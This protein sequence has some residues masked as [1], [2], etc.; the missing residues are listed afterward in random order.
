MAIYKIDPLI[1]TIEFK[2]KH[3][4]IANVNGRFTNFDAS[5]ETIHDEEDFS[6]ASILFSANV[7][8][9]STGIYDRDT[10]LRSADFFDASKWPKMHFI[11]K[12]VKLVEKS[13]YDI[14]GS[15]TIKDVTKEIK[16]D[17]V[18]T[19]LETNKNGVLKYGFVVKGNISRRDFNLN[20]N[21]MNGNALIDDKINLAISAQMIKL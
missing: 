4:M 10:H 3:L 16:L 9:I 18:Y 12:N 6:G 20:Y 11:S 8:S 5:M 2:V 14:L 19:G 1:S 13:Q 15:M 21:G 17:A 7:E